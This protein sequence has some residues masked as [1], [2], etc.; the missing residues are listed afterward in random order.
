MVRFNTFRPVYILGGL[1][2]LSPPITLKH[3]SV[4]SILVFHA[5]LEQHVQAGRSASPDTDK[6]GRIVPGR[7]CCVP[8]AAAG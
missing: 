3:A 5:R 8:F 7:E 6:D 2:Q 1:L 4:S